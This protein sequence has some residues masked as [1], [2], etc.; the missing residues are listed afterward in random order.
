MRIFL[1]VLDSVGVGYLPDAKDFDDV[2]SNTLLSASTARGFD[3]SNMRALGLFN[4]QGVDWCDDEPF[5]KGDFCRLNEASRGKDTTTGHW[6]IAGHISQTPFPLFPDGFPDEIIEKI[7]E[8]SGRD[9]LCNKPYSGTQVIKDYGKE[10]IKTGAIIVYTSADSVLQIAAHNDVVPLDELYRICAETRKIMQGKYGVG[11]VI[12]RPFIGEYPYVRTSD[13]HDYSLLPPLTMLDVLQQNGKTVLSVGKIIDIF[14]GKGIDRFVRTK[15]NK[16]GLD[17]TVDMLK[18]DFDGLCFVNL[19]DFDMTYGHRRDVQGYGDAL[20][21]FDKRVPEL[22]DG[23]KDDD[24][25]MFTAD[26]GCDPRY[27][28]TDH[29][30]EY[31]PLVVYGKKL[32]QGVDLGTRKT[33]ADIS[34]TILD[35]FG[36]TPIEGTSF[37]SDII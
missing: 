31:I 25:I 8:I 21:Y 30:R 1:I 32:K 34:A 22:L 3:M 4:I 15:D 18:E 11:R 23:L 26:H 14:A 6:E 37:K 17:K 5:P 20:T 36:I 7:K 19:V 13:R 12:A 10:H 9:V 35:F 2:G 27:K 28:G 29:T 24:V 16:D 33:Y